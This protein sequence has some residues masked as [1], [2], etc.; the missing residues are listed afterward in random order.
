MLQDVRLEVSKHPRLR[1]KSSENIPQL[2]VR[3]HVLAFE[4]AVE[5]LVRRVT[6]R[7][8]AE[9]P[10]NV[11]S[12]VMRVGSVRDVVSEHARI[13]NNACLNPFSLLRICGFTPAPKSDTDLLCQFQNSKVKKSGNWD[14]N[15]GLD[16]RNDRAFGE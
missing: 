16:G 11:D 15:W 12:R 1:R 4:P 14:G 10:E 13:V 5:L 8:R 7:V 9:P 3:F 2:D 6:L